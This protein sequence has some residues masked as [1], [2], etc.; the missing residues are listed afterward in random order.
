MR[1][2]GSDSRWGYKNKKSSVNWVFCFCVS[3]QG[4]EPEGK[5]ENG[6]F[7]L[8]RKVHE[9]PKVFVGVSSASDGDAYPVG[10]TLLYRFK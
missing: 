8:L 4:I 2:H 3:D 9:N 5:G 6:S 7:L 1:K 10:A